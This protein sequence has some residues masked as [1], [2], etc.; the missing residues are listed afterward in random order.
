LSKIKYEQIGRIFAVLEHFSKF[1]QYRPR[2]W[3]LF[4]L[5]C[6]ILT[7]NFF[8]LKIL[9]STAQFWAIKKNCPVFAGFQ[10]YRASDMLLS[11]NYAYGQALAAAY[12]YHPALYGPIPAPYG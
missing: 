6:Q 8:W 12:G 5:N 4:V 1:E 10:P 9:L 3:L 11:K 2:I 7:S